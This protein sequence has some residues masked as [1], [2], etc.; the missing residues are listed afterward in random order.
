MRPRI[1]IRG[2]V[3]PSVRQSIFP[4]YFRRWKYAYYARLVPCIWPC[5]FLFLLLSSRYCDTFATKKI[6]A[7]DLWMPACSFEL[8]FVRTDSPDWTRKKFLYFFFW[9]PLL[10]YFGL[11]IGWCLSMNYEHTDLRTDRRTIL[12]I[13][14]F[15]NLKENFMDQ[16]NAYFHRPTNVRSD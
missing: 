5:F 12:F 3:R 16:V 10:P 13:E 1:S 4:C 2:R 9:W 7:L 14:I 11:K 6:K 15:G 8:S